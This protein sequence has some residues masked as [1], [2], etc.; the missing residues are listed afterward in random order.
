[1]IQFIV[2]F[3]FFAIAT[4]AIHNSKLSDTRKINWMTIAFVAA[5]VV[6]QIVKVVVHGRG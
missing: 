6:F 4:I 5:L 3:V 2:A 1:M